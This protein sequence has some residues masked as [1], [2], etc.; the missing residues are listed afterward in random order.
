[1]TGTGTVD[2]ADAE[3]ALRSLARSMPNIRGALLA[4][5][6]G[7]PLAHHLPDR[8]PASTAAIVASSC[9]LGERL[10]ELTGDGSMREIVV[11][12]DDGYVVIYRVGDIGVLTVLTAPAVNLAML[13][14]KAR[15]V[16][17]RFAG[18]RT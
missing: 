13:K 15:D 16:V 4:S 2:Q 7:Y 17:I 10:A 12:S 18:D 11:N 5:L 14:L 6:D 1:M 3:A 9:G 8:D